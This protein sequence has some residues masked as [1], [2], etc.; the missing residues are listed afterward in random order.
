LICYNC[1]TAEAPR[2]VAGAKMP[3]PI[4]EAWTAF[5]QI[6]RSQSPPPPNGPVEFGATGANFLWWAYQGTHVYSHEEPRKTLRLLANIQEPYY[7]IVAAKSD[8]GITDLRRV[9]E[10]R[11]PLRILVGVGAEASAVLA[12]Y[13]LTKEV[14]ERAGGHFGSGMVPEERQ[15]FDVIIAGGTLANAP[16]FN[17]W[18]EVSQ[19]YDLTYLQLPDDLLGKIAKDNDMERGTIPDGL[20]RGI[21]HPIPTV[22]S[23]GTV[24]YGP[25][26]MPDS[27]AYTVAK[28]MDEHQDLLQWSHL[29]FSY[30]PRTVWKAYGVPLHPGAARYYRERGYMK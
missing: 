25:A 6:P 7:L 11:W 19:K 14:V 27:F 23:S 22:V 10:K 17:V 18:Y 4:E 24:V 26:D 12:Y 5:P 9:K 8:L 21:D 13:G 15:N 1:A 20:L 30:N 3:A 16:E 29:D 2:I 28:A